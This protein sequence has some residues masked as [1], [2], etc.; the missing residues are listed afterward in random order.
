[1]KNIHEQKADILMT[2]PT[3]D[4]RRFS[5]QCLGT[6]HALVVTEEEEEMQAKKVP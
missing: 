3:Q 5:S 4:W 6:H 2:K 1:M